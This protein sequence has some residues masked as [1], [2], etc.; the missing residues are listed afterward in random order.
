M[1]TRRKQVYHGRIIDLNLETVTLPNGVQAE[2]EIVRH[3]GGAAAVALD[4]QQRVCLLRQ[5][6]HAAGGWLWELPAG[7]LDAGETPLTT[8]RREL[9]EEAGVAAARWQALGR[10]VSS[11]AVLTEVIHLFLARDLT[12][13]EAGHEQHEVIEVHWIALDQA[14]AWA[15][16]DTILDAKTA[17]G[18]FRAQALLLHAIVARSDMFRDWRTMTHCLHCRPIPVRQI[19]LNR[20]RSQF[21]RSLR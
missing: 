9:Q 6:R 18:L 4:A 19:R 1:G 20:A 13:V 17:I 15:A 21:V 2:L 11:P 5:F 8:A 16:T 14:L 12:A 3:P 7:K 10:L